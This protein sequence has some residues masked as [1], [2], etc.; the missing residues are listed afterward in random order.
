MWPSFLQIELLPSR[1]SY[2]MR[3]SIIL[4]IETVY[5]AKQ[6]IVRAQLIS[7]K[8]FKFFSV[9]PSPQSLQEY[10]ES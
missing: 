5:L 4:A 7:C 3:F 10:E 2:G 9:E 1:N 8:Q 6:R